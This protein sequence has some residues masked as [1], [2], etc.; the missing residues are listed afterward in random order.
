MHCFLCYS[1]LF[2][3]KGETEEETENGPALVE[4]AL[5]KYDYG[6]KCRNDRILEYRKLTP[7]L[8]EKPARSRGSHTIDLPTVVISN[9]EVPVILVHGAPSQGHFCP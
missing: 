2:L 9:H 1:F 4:K 7:L 8:R 3:M 5:Y 6:K